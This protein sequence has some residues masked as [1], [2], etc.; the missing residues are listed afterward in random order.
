MFDLSG[1]TALV[2]GASSGIG[3]E[4]ARLFAADGHELVLLARGMPRLESTAAEIEAG[5]G[6]RAHLL[7]EDL[8]DPDAPDRIAERVER[9]GL[10]VDHLVNNAGFSAY[11]PFLETAPG[12]QRDMVQVNALAPTALARRLAPSM[13]ARGV[14]RILNVASTAAFQPGPRMAV[15]YATK[16]YLLSLSVA[17]SVELEA[18]GVTVTVLCPGP[19]RTGFSERAGLERSRMFNTD[20]FVSDPRQVARAGYQGMLR[21]ERVVVPGVIQKAHDVAVRFVPRGLA[22]RLVSGIQAPLD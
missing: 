10:V 6:I 1:R 5:H 18:S 20:W 8:A 3:R 16:A 12:V 21:G 4:L 22:A 11:G 9:L 15:Y 7:S 17:L 14:G 13:V 2:T 19:T